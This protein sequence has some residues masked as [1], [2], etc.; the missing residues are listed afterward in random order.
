MGTEEKDK[1]V[2]DENEVSEKETTETVEAPKSEGSEVIEPADKPVVE[3]I[4]P[5]DVASAAP[6]AP[7]KKKTGLAVGVTVGVVAALGAGGFGVVYAMDSKPENV[8]VSA[9]SDFLNTKS[10]GIDGVFEISQ[11]SS[12]LKAKLE[13]KSK[14]T[15]SHD[16]SADASLI[17]EAGGKEVKVSIGTVVMKDYTI[18]I[19]LDGLKNAAELALSMMPSGYSS[20][21]NTY[22]D[23]INDIVGEI[24]GAWWKI[25]VPELIDEVDALTSSN[26]SKAKEAWQ[27]FTSA[28]DKAYEKQGKYADLYK[29]N[30]FV[31]LEDYKG[32]KKSSAKGTAYKLKL[33]AGKLT[34]FANKVS[35]DF[36]DL[37]LTDCMNKLNSGN[38]TATV[39]YVDEE[40]YDE[41]A[42]FDINTTVKKV[43]LKEEDV[44]KA[45][46]NLPDVILTI[47]NGLFSHKLTGLYVDL[48][49]NQFTGKIDF[50]FNR[51]VKE[52]SAPSDA[53]SIS[54][55]IESI[56]K[57]VQKW[58]SSLY[59][60]YSSSSSLLDTKKCSDFLDENCLTF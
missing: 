24:D 32:D 3:T 37:G 15:A 20:A 54:K 28:A 29:E 48:S 21:A 44:K 7:R 30:A 47:E 8:A 41:D 1:K 22:E 9:I 39:R 6:A 14:S 16:S 58:Q 36:D 50:A 27:C 52:V 45:I 57:S 26:K 13:L 49:A 23:L 25:N 34:A 43:E 56:S 11:A 53:K 60:S 59:R 17:V 31:S 33:D 46:E 2:L 55:A 40:D 51:D 12:G 4:T 18:Y 5:T 10:M 42:D 38:K 19:K 35:N